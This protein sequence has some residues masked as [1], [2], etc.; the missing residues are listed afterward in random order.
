MENSYLKFH[1]VLCLISLNKDNKNYELIKHNILELL[2]KID[3]IKNSDE[4]IKFETSPDTN[5]SE[6]IYKYLTKEE[7]KNINY[8]ELLFHTL[9][10]IHYFNK[11]YE[12]LNE[13]LTLNKM[14][15][16]LEERKNIILY[17]LTHT[18]EEQHIGKDLNDTFLKD[19][20][21]LYKKLIYGEKQE[22]KQF[23]EY[24]KQRFKKPFEIEFH[25][26]DE[27]IKQYKQNNKITYKD[28]DDII[29]NA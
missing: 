10:E 9:T 18:I 19:Y 16:L 2:N 26:R 12:Q 22:Y 24:E 1:T 25:C 8:S 21:P 14:L 29:K 15:E 28:F 4:L 13:P 5:Y 27:L 20:Q 7:A 23:N 11:E 3:N 6:T 17:N